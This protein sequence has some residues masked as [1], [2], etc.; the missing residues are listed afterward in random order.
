MSSPVP[1]QGLSA[2]SAAQRL[3]E[4]GPNALPADQRRSLGLIARE[5]LGEPMFLLLLGAGVLYLLLGDLQEGLILFGFVLLVLGLTLY[6]EGKTEKALAALRDLSS[7]RALV[8]RDGQ[9]LRIAGLDVVR[10]DVL[11]LAEG[12]RIA[13]DA[14][15]IS[16]SGVQVDESLLT[17]EPVPVSKVVAASPDVPVTARPGGDGQ[18]TLFSGTLLVSGHGL[19]RVTATGARS[20][21]GRIGSALQTLKPE[22]SPLKKQTARLVKVLALLA[23]ATSVLLVLAY[24]LLR[25]DWLAALLAGIALAMAMLP[26]E[27]TVVLTVIPALGAWRLSRQNVLTRRLAA[28]ET[29][30]AAS[31]LCVD[32]T[33]TLTENRMT[34]AQLYAEAA[35]ARLGVWAAEVFQRTQRWLLAAKIR[36]DG[37]ERVYQRLGRW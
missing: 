22:P 5:T 8:L 35:P 4:D 14:V 15:L 29:L 25:G 24:G 37:G 33:G 17:G 16:G 12:D 7:P 30:G 10:G 20:E 27:F 2:T 23:L 36:L 9:P 34:V 28:I 3:Q 19:A 18:S 26:Q 31:V 21:I 11:V 1:H 13:A 6:Q 32:K